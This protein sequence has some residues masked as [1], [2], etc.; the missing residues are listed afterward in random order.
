MPGRSRAPGLRD[1]R[2]RPHDRDQHHRGAAVS[3]KAARVPRRQKRLRVHPAGRRTAQDAADRRVGIR[4]AGRQEDQS[5]RRRAGAR[6][7]R[8]GRHRRFCRRVLPARHR[9][10]ADPH[11][12]PCAGG[13]VGGRQNRR[14]SQR[15]QKPHRR[16]PPA[17]G[18][19]RGHRYAVDPA[20]PGALGGARGG[21]QIRVHRGPAISRLARFEHG[22]APRAG[23]GGVDLRDPPLMR[24]QGGHCRG[25]RARTGTAR[26]LEFRPYVRSR[27]RGRDRLSSAICM[28]RRSRSAC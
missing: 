7:R 20:G 12:A 23:R 22:G 11:H 4:R 8:G 19:D 18:G 13:L 25:G 28:A 1:P 9:L 16:L 27:H 14:Q 15:R 10:R 24:D 26:D 21:H 3:C 5:G 17:A 6:W 2:Q